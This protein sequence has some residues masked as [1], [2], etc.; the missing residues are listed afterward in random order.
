MS[1]TAT[2]VWSGCCIDE[3]NLVQA[4]ENWTALGISRPSSHLE[5]Y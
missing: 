1:C 3:S 4:K 2:G 5:L